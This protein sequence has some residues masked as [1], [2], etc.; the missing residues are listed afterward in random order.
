MARLETDEYT[1]VLAVDNLNIVLD[2]KTEGKNFL[3]MTFPDEPNT[4][5]I[6][7]FPATGRDESS[8]MTAT[9]IPKNNLPAYLSFCIKNMFDG[10]ENKGVLGTFMIHHVYPHFNILD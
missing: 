1:V 9:T 8:E 3:F 10:D 6:N 2:I 5:H 7:E 4:I